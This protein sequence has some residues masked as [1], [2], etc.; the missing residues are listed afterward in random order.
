MIYSV[1]YLYSH[2]KTITARSLQYNPDKENP[3]FKYAVQF[4]SSG[5]LVGSVLN[6]IDSRG[7]RSYKYIF[8]TGG[9]DG[10]VYFVFSRS[11]NI[12][13]R[14][15]NCCNAYLVSCHLVMPDAN[16][17]AIH[18]FFIVSNTLV[19]RNSH[20]LS[21]FQLIQCFCEFLWIFVH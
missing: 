16:Y 2:G 8:E 10:F 20:L 11:G 6:S 4:K 21:S 19:C 17:W 1:I 14:K 9:D 12:V 15:I 5:N 3:I 13:S 7:T 18:T